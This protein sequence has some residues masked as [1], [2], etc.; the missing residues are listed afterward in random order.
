MEKEDPGEIER[1]GHRSNSGEGIYE[2][3]YTGPT[4]I[5][6]TKL[7]VAMRSSPLELWL[8]VGI[9][10]IIAGVVAYFLLV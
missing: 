10:L 1:Y 4:R 8:L 2:T 9:N 3:I 6:R 5:R 7:L